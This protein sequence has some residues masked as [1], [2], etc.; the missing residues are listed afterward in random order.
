MDLCCWVRFTGGKLIRSYYYLGESGE[1]YW[2][3]GELTSEEKD[4]G[5]TFLP[6]EDMEEDDWENVTFPDED[7]VDQLADK[8]GVDP[9]MGKYQNTRS[10]GYLCILK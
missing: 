3:E 10:A 8:W 1:V 7:I 5:M 9:H 2:N 4:L 6:C